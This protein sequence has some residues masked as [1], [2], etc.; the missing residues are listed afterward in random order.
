MSKKLLIIPIAIIAIIVMQLPFTEDTNAQGTTAPQDTSVHFVVNPTST[1]PSSTR[2]GVN[3]GFRTTYGSEQ[4]MKNILW[5][6]GFEGTIDRA[7]LIVQ[8]TDSTSF[9]DN[10]TWGYANG[11]WNG[12]SFEVRSGASAG[13]TGTIQSSLMAGPNGSPQYITAGAPPQLAPN[14]VVI[15]TKPV[16]PNPHVFIGW[17][18]N[19]SINPDSQTRPGST[20]TQSLKMSPSPNNWNNAEFDAY[21]DGMDPT[22]G[23]LLLVNGQWQ[24]SFWMIADSSQGSLQVSFGR[25]NGSAPFS[26]KRFRQ[27]HP[28]SNIR[29]ILPATTQVRLIL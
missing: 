15:V 27:R 10:N 12:A 29:S 20:G 7:L 26:P 16:D 6:P 8:S 24:L 21:F 1:T 14:D 23:N 18:S 28:G 4:F 13:V 25:Q 17:N 9:Y 19:G 22:V 3:M 5:N 11:Y 2:V